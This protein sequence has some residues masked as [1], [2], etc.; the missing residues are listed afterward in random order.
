[1]ATVATVPLSVPQN[2][3]RF[4]EKDYSEET[5]R[6]IDGEVSRFI[7]E[8][9]NRVRKILTEKREQREF[10]SQTLLEK[11]TVLGDELQEL[12]EASVGEAQESAGVPS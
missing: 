5:A 7:S 4:K 1:M 10:L 12:L 8:A 2:H 3:G 9:H 11:E 6:E